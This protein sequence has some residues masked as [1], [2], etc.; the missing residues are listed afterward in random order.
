M[1]ISQENDEYDMKILIIGDTC[2]KIY[3]KIL[4]YSSNSNYIGVGKTSLLLRYCNG[5][6]TSTYMTTIGVDFKTKDIFVYDTKVKLKVLY[7]IIK[8]MGY[9]WSRKI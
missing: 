8:D 1:S 9:C 4:N 5:T 3:Y 6:F 7:N 2:I